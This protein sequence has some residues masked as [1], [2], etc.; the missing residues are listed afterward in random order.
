MRRTL[1]YFALLLLAAVVL[2]GCAV[3]FSVDTQ[4][5]TVSVPIQSSLFSAEQEETVDIPDEA[6]RD[7]LVYDEVR[8]HYEV[9]TDTSSDT[10]ARVWISDDQTTDDTYTDSEEELIL[11][12]S[13]PGG[14][15][16][17]GWKES[18]ELVNALNAQHDVFV[19]GGTARNTLGTGTATI[20]LYAEITGTVQPA[21]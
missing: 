5:V 19:V 9:T 8:I 20:T 14:E 10:E 12:V 3:P 15:T 17:T 16:I 21:R 18:Q 1:T 11:S 7:E 13:V 4:P 6:T 2:A